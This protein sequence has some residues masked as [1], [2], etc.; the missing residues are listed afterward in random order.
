MPGV[1]DLCCGIGGDAMGLAEPEAVDQS[2]LRAWMAGH[3]A[4]CVSRAGD[5]EREPV[6]GR[7][8]HIDPARRAGG[9]RIT[10]YADLLPGPAVLE[11][12]AAEARGCAIKLAPGVDAALLPPG[13]LEIISRRGTLNQAVLWTGELAGSPRSATLV[14]G[15]RIH[16]ISGVPGEAQHAE[17]DRFIAAVDPAPERAGLLGV[18]GESVGLGMPHP[19]LGLFTAAAPVASPWL[20]WFEVLE[21]LPW[22]RGRVASAVRGH[23]GGIAQVKTRG[24]A[25]DPDV[26]QARLRGPGDAIL[27]VFVYRFGDG[28]RVL[29]LVTRR[30][31]QPP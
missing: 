17:I 20:T 23:G 21:V 1:L 16:T 29:A 3:N 27:T 14:E 15:E 31:A 12:I 6:A 4:G 9:S 8:V 18:L 19:R 10:R 30:L 25:V 22:H 13:E 26:E 28:G 2:P 5:A 7:F 24:R 11:R